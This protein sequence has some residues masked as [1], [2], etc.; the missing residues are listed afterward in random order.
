MLTEAH[1]ESKEKNFRE[2]KAVPGGG[3]ALR[4]VKLCERSSS[5]LWTHGDS[6]GD[7]DGGAW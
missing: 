5:S 1:R 2:K 6:D 7:R 4:W 3:F